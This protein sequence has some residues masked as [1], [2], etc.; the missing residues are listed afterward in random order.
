MT[1]TGLNPNGDDG[2][3]TQGVTGHPCI[4]KLYDVI[5]TPEQLLI[6]TEKCRGQ[7]LNQI[8]RNSRY[9][10]K[11]PEEV[12]VKIIFQ[13][14]SALAYMHK[15]NMAHGNINLDSILINLDNS[16]Y[17][18]VKMINLGLPKIKVN[19]FQELTGVMVANLKRQMAE[20][21]P[22][23]QQEHTNTDFAQ[24]IL[25]TGNLLFKLLHGYH[26]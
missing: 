6:L 10:G 16:V 17:L 22:A 20:L 4:V 14:L 1:N 26:P 15:R 18:E 19:S 24:D 23:P 12:A 25:D 8:T 3:D 9:A 2:A 21:L 13:I 5:G 11:L 7:T